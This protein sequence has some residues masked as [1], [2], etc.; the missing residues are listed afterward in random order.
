MLHLPC[1]RHLRAFL[2]CSFSC[3]LIA[4]TAKAETEIRL[5]TIGNS[6]AENVTEFLPQL[7]AAH[8]VK[9]TISRANLGGTGLNRHTRHLK[10]AQ[11]DPSDPE[12]RP[13]R[14]RSL[15]D[16]PKRSLIEI[17]EPDTWDYITIQQFS[18]DSYKPESYEPYAGELIAA[19]RQYAPSAEILV[20]QTW[21][22]R[23]DHPWFLDPA[24]QRQHAAG[25]TLLT[26][27]VMYASIVDAYDQI[28]T[29]YGLRQLPVG[30]AFHL[31]RQLPEWSYTFPDP[32]FDYDHPI[33]GQRPD[34]PGSLIAGWYWGTNRETGADEF[35]LDAKHANTAGR[36][37][38]AHVLL[39][40]MSD[41][42]GN[43]PL[44]WPESL[45]AAQ[46]ASL[47]RVAHAA[48]TA[49]ETP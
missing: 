30:D 37:L 27:A 41:R 26:Q 25:E 44:W 15:P 5:L 49:R 33:K 28:A 42:A 2:V 13:Y 3:L 24:Q 10:I 39:E 31:A 46:A 29:R 38:G 17:L 35:R 1:F 7:A 20:L 21:A 18:G 45:T 43:A 47:Q 8:G 6:F 32:H 9:L 12:G 36:Y 11:T 40:V 34:Q 23:T 19:I 14:N 16:Q 48:V 4:T 22:Y